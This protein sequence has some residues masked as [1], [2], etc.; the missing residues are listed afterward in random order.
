MKH[1]FTLIVLLL[2]NLNFLVIKQMRP[3][4]TPL[5]SFPGSATGHM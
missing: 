1:Y 3:P 2:P 5:K 4:P